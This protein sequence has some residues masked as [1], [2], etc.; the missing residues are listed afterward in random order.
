MKIKIKPIVKIFTL[1][2]SEGLSTVTIRQVKT[3]DLIQLAELFAEQT[4]VWDDVDVGTIQ[5]KRKWNMEALKQERAFCTLVG[6]DLQNEE[7]GVDIFK[8]KSGKNGPELAMNRNEFIEAWGS[9]DGD[10]TDEIYEFVK[11]VNPVFD[12]EAKSGE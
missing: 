10:L 2:D 8:F 3:A 11:E 4:Q 9:L 6:A 5:M 12:P 1:K 7:T